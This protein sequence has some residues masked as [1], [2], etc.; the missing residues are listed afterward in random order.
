M[1]GSRVGTAQ[2]RENADEVKPVTRKYGQ[3]AQQRSLYREAM[4]IETPE[5]WT[6]YRNYIPQVT[7]IRYRLHTRMDHISESM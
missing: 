4:S 7:S 1:T 6:L 5:T 2:G 3:H